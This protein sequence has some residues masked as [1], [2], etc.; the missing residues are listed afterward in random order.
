MKYTVHGMTTTLLSIHS[1]FTVCY[2]TFIVDRVGLHAQ[3]I[4]SGLLQ[5]IP[6]CAAE[7]I[8]SRG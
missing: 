7:A 2:S 3:T 6:S 1:T 4:I 8:L 5:D